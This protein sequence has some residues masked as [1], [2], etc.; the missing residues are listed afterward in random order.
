MIL[1]FETRI[2]NLTYASSVYID[3]RIVNNE[4]EPLVFEHCLLCKLPMMV[5]CKL[6]NLQLEDLNSKECEYDNGGY[7]IINGSEK[8]LIAQEK[9]NNN[10]GV[11][12]CEKAAEQISVYVGAQ[13]SKR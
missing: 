4:D 6:C 2:R 5:G 13:R 9:M 3:I 8:V 10:Q 11:R 1:P 7:F 12:V